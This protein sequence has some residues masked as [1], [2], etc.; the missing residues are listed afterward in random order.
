MRGFV[1][2]RI[3]ASEDRLG[4][5][6]W[7]T[8]DAGKTWRMETFNITPDKMSAVYWMNDLQGLAMSNDLS[9]QLSLVTVAKYSEVDPCRFYASYDFGLT[10]KEQSFKDERYPGDVNFS[11]GDS[12]DQF[13]VIWGDGTKTLILMPDSSP[14]MTGSYLITS[15]GDSLIAEDNAL[16]FIYTGQGNWKTIQGKNSGN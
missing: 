12:D 7:A 13:M 10:W 3:I 9:V 14:D 6:R 8:E 11:S 5:F 2:E 16:E 4:S 1:K 15:W